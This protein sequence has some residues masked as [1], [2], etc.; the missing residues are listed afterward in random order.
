MKVTEFNQSDHNGEVWLH[1]GHLKDSG[2]TDLSTQATFVVG[3]AIQVPE[4]NLAAVQPQGGWYS[5]GAISV[6]M[7][8]NSVKQDGMLIAAPKANTTGKGPAVQ[9]NLSIVNT[10]TLAKDQSGKVLDQRAAV[11]DTASAQFD[12]PVTLQINMGKAADLKNIPAGQEPYVATYD[13]KNAIWV[14]VPIQAVDYADNTVTVETTH[15][16]TW[17]AGLGNSLPQNGTGAL[18]F[19]QPYTALFTGTA[20]YSVPIW[21]PAGRAGMA[22]N[23]AL[24][25]S[26]ATVDGVLGDVQALGVTTGRW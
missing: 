4:V 24:S 20:R 21:T 6:F 17:G 12:K 11:D 1:S 15:F 13:E 25:Y 16:S 23:I 8:K 5:A 9:Y 18:L 19:D 3:M 2:K 7:P 26:S 22:P 14:K 10:G